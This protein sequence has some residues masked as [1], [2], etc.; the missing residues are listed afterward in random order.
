MNFNVLGIY[1]E[2]AAAVTLTL[3]NY[4]LNSEAIFTIYIEAGP[5]PTV[6]EI[7][8]A[9][10]CTKDRDSHSARPNSNSAAF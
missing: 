7:K 6:G 3:E 5:R 1:I 2:T 4:I 10:A 9:N 8:S